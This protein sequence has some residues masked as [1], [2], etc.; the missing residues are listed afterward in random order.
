[1]VDKRV[2]NTPLLEPVD[3][4]TPVS[5]YQSDFMVRIRD[6]VPPRPAATPSNSAPVR[7]RTSSHPPAADEPTVV[8]EPSNWIDDPIDPQPDT[9]HMARRRYA[10]KLELMLIAAI[11]TLL[12]AAAALWL[13]RVIVGRSA[14]TSNSA[15]PAGTESH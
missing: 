11:S 13:N 4:T 14:G 8:V 2:S 1:M 5:T 9:L 6:T 7:Q 12:V 15:S 10:R 3:E